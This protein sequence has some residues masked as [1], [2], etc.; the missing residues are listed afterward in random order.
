MFSKIIMFLCVFLYAQIGVAALVNVAT[1]STEGSGV[2]TGALNVKV[3]GALY[4]VIFK[5]QTCVDIFDGCDGDTEFDFQS[6]ADAIL[7]SEALR[8]QVYGGDF[9]GRAHDTAPTETFGIGTTFGLIVTPYRSD[10]SS[11]FYAALK[12]MPGSETDLIIQGSLGVSLDATDFLSFVYA[13]WTEV[14]AV[15][16]PA[17]VWLFGSGLIG[18]VG[19]A[20]RKKS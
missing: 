15:P 13:D 5:E 17:A 12:N 4:D 7:A 2:V 11:V 10:G 18:L 19:V 14:S 16:V 3:N 6:S 20:R 8:D 1:G 9:D